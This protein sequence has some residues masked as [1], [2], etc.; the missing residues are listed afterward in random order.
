MKKNLLNTLP[1]TKD[2]EPSLE[3]LSVILDDEY[4]DKGFINTLY[5][6]EDLALDIFIFQKRY[7]LHTKARIIFNAY[8]VTFC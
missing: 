5:I 2:F 6:E 8:S 4:L 7:S 1:N 3:I